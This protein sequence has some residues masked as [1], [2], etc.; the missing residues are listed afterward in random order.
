M[1]VHSLSARSQIVYKFIFGFLLTHPDD[2]ASGA[3]FE[4]NGFKTMLSDVEKGE[5]HSVVVKDA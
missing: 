5:I 4:R 2:G 3:N 1:N